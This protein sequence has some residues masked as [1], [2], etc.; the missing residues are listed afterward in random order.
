[1]DTG[2]LARRSRVECHHP[3]GTVSPVI[4]FPV[5]Y[6]TDGSGDAEFTASR[7]RLARFRKR[8]TGCRPERRTGCSAPSADRTVRSQAGHPAPGPA[9]AACGRSTTARS[10]PRPTPPPR[11]GIGTNDQSQESGMSYVE[12]AFANLRH[13]LEITETESKLAQARHEAIR[14]HVRGH[15]QVET[16]FLTGSYRR[17]KNQKAQGRRHLH[18]HRCA[19]PAESLPQPPA[20]PGSRCAARAPAG[21]VADARRDGMAIVIPYGSEDEIM[22]MDVVPAFH[23]KAGGY[24]IPDPTPADGSPPTRISTARQARPRT[25]SATAST[26][27]SSR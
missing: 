1:M 15:W 11:C 5:A 19:R 7:A 14:A 6:R 9:P 3:G 26:C 25:R 21:E 20:R 17:D 18:R 16:D 4:E 24:H 8:S 27:R 2:R 10:A 13:T 12:D 23:R 22:S